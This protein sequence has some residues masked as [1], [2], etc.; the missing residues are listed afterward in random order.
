MEYH[1]QSYRSYCQVLLE[2]AW[3]EPD[4]LGVHL[5]AL[6]LIAWVPNC[7]SLLI[8]LGYPAFAFHWRQSL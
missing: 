7:H 2:L 5:E 1:H 4:S 3:Q 6:V 8:H